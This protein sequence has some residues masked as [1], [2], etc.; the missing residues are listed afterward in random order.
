MPEEFLDGLEFGF[1]HVQIFFGVLG[2]LLLHGILRLVEVGFHALL[3]GDDVSAQAVAGGSLLALQ[4]IQRLRRGRGAAVE[5][6][7][8]LLDFLGLRS[9]IGLGL[10]SLR[11]ICAG[12]G[13][14]SVVL[15]LRS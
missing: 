13:R 11:V 14:L 9:R 1:G 2:I 5:I 3:G 15:R 7:V 8:F 4:I 6:I 10:G 12:D